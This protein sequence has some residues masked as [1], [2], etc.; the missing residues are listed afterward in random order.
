MASLF[1]IPIIL[2]MKNIINIQGNNQVFK[3][4]L[5]YLNTGDN[6]E[7][8]DINWNK[9]IKD[10]QLFTDNIEHY[11]VKNEYYQNPKKK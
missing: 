11:R 5:E 7:G 1:S 10:I 6:I 9:N 8:K 3:Y 4:L 2:L